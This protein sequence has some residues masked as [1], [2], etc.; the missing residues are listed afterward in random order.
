MFFFSVWFLHKLSFVWTTE[1]LLKLYAL[2]PVGICGCEGAMME[3]ICVADS[4]ELSP[5]FD[6]ILTLKC[7][8]LHVYT[9]LQSA[10]SLNFSE[11]SDFAVLSLFALSCLFLPA[12]FCSCWCFVVTL[13][14]GSKISSNGTQDLFVLL[15]LIF[16]WYETR[17]GLVMRRRQL[18]WQEP[19]FFLE[20]SDCSRS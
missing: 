16:S 18:F 7:R 20:K 3:W 1:E 13:G 8:Y 12:C 9:S 15:L 4:N 6:K 5:F 10:W 11:S 17:D 2:E 14:A 19:I